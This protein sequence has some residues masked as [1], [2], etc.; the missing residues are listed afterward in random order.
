MVT[1][2][3]TKLRNTTIYLPIQYARQWNVQKRDYDYFSADETF[4]ER[5]NTL[6]RDYEYLSQKIQEMETENEKFKTERIP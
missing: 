4:E 2:D 3:Y 1:K 5:I 6:T